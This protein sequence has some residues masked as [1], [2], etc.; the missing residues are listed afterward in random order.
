LSRKKSLPAESGSLKK[1]GS[2]T[3]SITKISLKSGKGILGQIQ[4]EK[5]APES[6]ILKRVSPTSSNTKI[7]TKSGRA[8]VVQS[9]KSIPGS[10]TAAKSWKS[11]SMAN[12]KIGTSQNVLSSPRTS[13]SGV[14]DDIKSSNRLSGPIKA[15]RS[16]ASSPPSGDGEK[17]Q[18]GSR[19]NKGTK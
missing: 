15:G 19:S 14:H 9:D 18:R 6:P 12:Y 3:N 7:S 13:A 5:S 10:P 4:T 17:F 16:A 2:P 8:S 11:S 1:G